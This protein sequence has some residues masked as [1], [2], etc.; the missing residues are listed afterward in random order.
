ML[1]RTVAPPPSRNDPGRRT[2]TGLTRRRLLLAGALVLNLVVLYAPDPGSP[3]GSGLGLD[4]LVHAGIFALLVLTGLRAGLAPGWFLPAVLAH[5][6]ISELVQAT[7]LSARAGD[8]ADAVAD[9]AGT[10]LGYV[11]YRRWPGREISSPTA[12]EAGG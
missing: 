11:A 1:A 12:A 7:L 9:A 8:L 10:V 3:P 2:R 4:K 6:A 5:A